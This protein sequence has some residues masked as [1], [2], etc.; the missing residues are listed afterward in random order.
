[1]RN[2]GLL[3]IGAWV[4]AVVLQTPAL[5]APSPAPQ[6]AAPG[7]AVCTINDSRLVELSGIVALPDGGYVVENDS[8][9]QATAMRVF[10]L[11]SKCRLSRQLLYPTAARDPE[12]LAVA[13]DGTVWVADIGDNFTN[14]PKDRRETIALW[15]LPQGGGAPIVHRLTYPDGPHDAE[16][17]LFGAGD[18]P[19]IVTKDPS[20]TAQIYQPTDALQANTRQGVPLKNVGSWK[21][22][23][24]GTPNFLGAA[25]QV[26]VTGAAQSPDRKR[27]VLRT[28]SDAYEWDAPDGDVV[29]AMK[30]GEPRIT[31]LPNEPQGEGIS[32]SPDGKS[33]LTCSDQSGPSKILRYQPVNGAP[34]AAGATEKPAKKADTRSWYKKLTLPQIIDIVAGVGVLGLVLV[35]IGVIGIRQ[36]RKA[37]RQAAKATKAK[38]KDGQP[39]GANDEDGRPTAYLSTVSAD[40]PPPS[41]GGTYSGGS[42]AQ[43]GYDGGN[44]YGG[45]YQAGYDQGNGRSA[46][47]GEFSQPGYRPGYDGDERY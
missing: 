26:L 46:G 24:T 44:V 33:F 36:S 14:A 5:A 9:D 38:A 18:V 7:E 42:Y 27:F 23:R 11:D 4:G 28:Y 22:K 17:L 45:G 15:K 3:V 37:R 43:P 10:Y 30:S 31:P 47:R 34:A 19:V 20:G 12:D 2:V 35:V 6:S 13:S 29:K 16:A 25:G 32:Y 40:P 39:E 8:N 41:A 1:M 21:P